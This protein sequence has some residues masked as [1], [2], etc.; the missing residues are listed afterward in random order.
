MKSLVTVVL[1]AC[2]F[3]AVGCDDKKGDGKP[4]STSAAATATGAAKQAPAPAKSAAP[5]GGW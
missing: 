4:A 5:G 2:A 1:L 3:A